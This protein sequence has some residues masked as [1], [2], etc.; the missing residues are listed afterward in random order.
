M[1]PSAP[2]SSFVPL[3]QP[4]DPVASKMESS[5]RFVKD[6]HCNLKN[7]NLAHPSPAPSMEGEVQNARSAVSEPP[8]IESHHLHERQRLAPPLPP[9]FFDIFD[10]T[11]LSPVAPTKSNAKLYTRDVIPQALSKNFS[12]AYPI[13]RMCECLRNAPACHTLCACR[14]CTGETGLQAG[15]FSDRVI[16]SRRL[17][18]VR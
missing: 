8:W 12:C 5:S 6:G 4:P 9:D 11:V 17:R 3:C 7:T 15:S 1:L 14:S 18:R 13:C 10:I 2:V 16:L